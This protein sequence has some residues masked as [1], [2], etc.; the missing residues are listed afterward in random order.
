MNSHC[1]SILHGGLPAASL[2][3]A[4]LAQAQPVAA[5]DAERTLPAVRVT[6][7][8][9]AAYA[10]PNATTGT[11]TDTE[12]KDVPQT[13][14][15]VPLQELRDRGV[16][17]LTDVFNTV[18]GTQAGTGYGGLGNGYGTY[19]RGFGSYT[20]YRDGFRDF[21]FVSARDIALFERVE[22]LKG[23][24]SVLYGTNDPGGIVNYVAKRPSLTAA[25]EATL[26][27]SS[28]RARRG[29]IDL[30]GPIG[31]SGQWAYRLIA[32]ADERDSHRDFVSS[33]TRLL[34]PSLTWRPSA[35]TAVTLS[36]ESVR[37][38]YTF[39]RG[40]PVEPE[41]IALPRE[42]FLEEPGL[43]R[44]ELESNRVVL[45]A[46]HRL[47]ETWSLRGAL[48]WIKPT[49][50]KLNFYPLG[51]QADRRTLDRSLDFSREFQKD[52]A[53]QLELTGK[54]ATGGVQHTLLAGLEHYRNNFHYTFAPF[55]LS[56]SID[57]LAP[58]YGQVAIP[59]G[60]LDTVAFGNDYGSRTTALYLQDQ[61]TFSPKWKGIVGLRYDR[62]RLFNDDLVDP[63]ASL[64]PQ[65]ETRV[66]PRFGVVYQPVETRSL[67]LGYSTSFNPQIFS[68]L[69]SGDLPKP[70]VGQQLEAGWRE[71]WFG[72]ALEST[73]SVFEIRKRNVT[74]ADPANP[75]LSIQVGEQ[76]SRGVELEVRGQPVRGLDLSL[77]M[78][79]IDAR[80]TKDNTLPVGD[81]LDSAPKLSASLWLKYQPQAIGWFAGGGVFH[82]GEREGTLPNSGVRLPA[83]TRVDA[84][85][86]YQARDW[87][88]QFNLRNLGDARTFLPYSGLFIPGPGRNGELSLRYHF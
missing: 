63:S 20:N 10:P 43:N 45:D 75:L 37:Q 88:L 55:D 15:V 12:L 54:F 69:S 51:L 57:I 44:A 31:T 38:H 21:S 79:W 82:L 68:P 14:N 42:R 36:A 86:G 13:V 1:A 83:E 7:K 8:A 16:V 78:A 53:L 26:S 52:Q 59:P 19:I 34:A 77:G 61:L 18:P 41:L 56:S 48:S 76:R 27:L 25:R 80:V 3:L 49:I 30:T 71:A 28:Y 66:S 81:R 58:V 70:E 23:P 60:F 2:W 29:E 73:L 85:L 67:F 84:L 64:R 39:E 6:G 65:T 72:Q 47:N 62:A 74:T 46:N 87:E 4:A 40:F 11:R 22:V 17:K 5:P 35:A 50:E 24:A 33:D 32:V 9:E